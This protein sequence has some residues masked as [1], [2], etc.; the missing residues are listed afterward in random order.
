MAKIIPLGDQVL[1]EK[2]DMSADEVRESGIIIPASAKQDK[3]AMGKIVAV[4]PEHKKVK[5]YDLKEGDMVIYA[6][7]AGTD[8]NLDGKEYIL[9]SVKD[10]LAKVEE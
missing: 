4:N 7:Y 9:V 1:L 8:I 6:R 3:P 5:K 10:I 2:V